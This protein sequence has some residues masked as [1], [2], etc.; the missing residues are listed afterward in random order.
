MS[1]EGLRKEI[2]AV[3]GSVTSTTTIEAKLLRLI[4]GL[5]DELESLESR[6][7]DDNKGFIDDVMTVVERRR[8]RKKPSKIGRLLRDSRKGPGKRSRGG[9]G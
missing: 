9:P 8:G 4:E 7:N 2:A 6:M 1:I 5:T 3:K